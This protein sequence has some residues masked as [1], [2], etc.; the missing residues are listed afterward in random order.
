MKRFNNIYPLLIIGLL[1]AVSCRQE[2][3]DDALQKTGYLVVGVS[4]GLDDIIEIK[5]GSD[6]IVYH[7]DV[8]DSEGNVDFSTD[9]HRLVSE[10]DP[11]ELLMG[12]YTVVASHG[13]AG[14]GFNI[15]CFA[16]ENSVRVYAEKPSSVDI[17][18]KMSKVKVSALFP[19][20]EEFNNMF[21][22]CEFSV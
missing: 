18:C 12:K 8:Y 6:E 13:Q 16:G 10:Q 14:T 21:P 7:L 2:E 20:D 15:P 4:Q 22:F 1:T 19:Q 3:L 9:D 5:S 17:L 11:I